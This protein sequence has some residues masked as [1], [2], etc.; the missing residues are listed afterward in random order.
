M[1]DSFNG[2][3]EEITNKVWELRQGGLI[4][5][6]QELSQGCGDSQTPKPLKEFREVL[7]MD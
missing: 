1:R 3:E 5:Q 7:G 2:N 4:Q 6:N